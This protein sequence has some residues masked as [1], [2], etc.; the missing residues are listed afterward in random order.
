M[1]KIDS[2]I[3]TR[4]ESI[5]RMEDGYI[6]EFTNATFKAFCLEVIS[7]GLED[8]K[9][10]EEGESKAKRL[11]GFWKNGTKIKIKQLS[12]KLLERWDVDTKESEKTEEKKESIKKCKEYF[13]SYDT[14]EFGVVETTIGERLDVEI[15]SHRFIQEQIEKASKKLDE[16]DFSGAITNSRSLLEQVLK[17]LVIKLNIENTSHE[18]PRLYKDVARA[19]DMEVDSSPNENIKTIL[20][21]FV[22][23]VQGMSALRNEASD[24]H[25]R[26]LEPSKHHAILAV[27]TSLTVCDFLLNSYE[28][29]NNS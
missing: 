21:G 4:M 1:S 8:L 2:T 17:E 7:E 9:Y 13:D 24:A 5:L 14:S 22:S 29:Q 23:I 26:G 15:L 20:R 19:M 3:K 10:K 16:E 28:Y 11:R 18:L 12:L 27:N 6:L 25:G